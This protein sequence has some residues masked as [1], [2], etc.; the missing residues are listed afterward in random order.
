[1]SDPSPYS[2]PPQPPIGLSYSRS[3]PDPLA[4]ARRAS[5]MLF[6]LGGL[7]LLLGL[8]TG[9]FVAS[10]TTE[11][12]QLVADQFGKNAPGAAGV[13]TPRLIRFLYIGMAIAGCVI[14]PWFILLGYFVRRASKAACV[15]SAIACGLLLLWM[16]MNLLSSVLMGVGGNPIGLV[17]ACVGIIPVV[18]LGLTMTWLMQTLR[19]LPQIQAMR[20]HWQTNYT[21]AQQ[22]QQIYNQGSTVYGHVGIPPANY[23]QQGYGYGAP[24]VV[25]GQ[26]QQPD[27]PPVRHPPLP[28]DQQNPPQG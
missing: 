13:L 22:Q 23:G 10:V 8:C 19:A 6:V 4:P 24:P 25:G 14:G 3:G 18:L 15:F 11:Q 27:R 7:A 20:E 26:P 2:P 17:S 16:V 21:A 9:L 28:P 12:L 1:L 5:T